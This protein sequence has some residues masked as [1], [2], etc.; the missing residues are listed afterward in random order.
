MMTLD[1]HIA[2]VN[3]VAYN[4]LFPSTLLKYVPSSSLL[5]KLLEK[6]ISM[7]STRVISADGKED[8]G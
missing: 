6:R 4:S 2:A 3:L 8:S 7:N 5:N 1:R